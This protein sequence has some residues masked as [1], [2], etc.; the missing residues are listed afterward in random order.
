MWKQIREQQDVF[1]GM[2][3]Y[4]LTKFDLATP[5]ADSAETLPGQRSSRRLFR[6]FVVTPPTKPSP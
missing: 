6:T 1:S 5:G 3:A 4:M 2:F